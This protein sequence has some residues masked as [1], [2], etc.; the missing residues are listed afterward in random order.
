MQFAR[1]N[2][3][4]NRIAASSSAINAYTNTEENNTTTLYLVIKPGTIKVNFHSAL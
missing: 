1:I 2:F 3:R 4:E